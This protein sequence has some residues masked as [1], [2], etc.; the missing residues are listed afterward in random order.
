MYTIEKKNVSRL[1]A[2]R[3][4]GSVWQQTFQPAGNSK[5]LPGLCVPSLWTSIGRWNA[6]TQ[7]YHAVHLTSVRNGLASRC[8]VSRP[9]EATRSRFHESKRR[10]RTILS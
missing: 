4:R 10:K 3:D 2:P 1:N 9:R 6:I 7:S 8:P 5:S